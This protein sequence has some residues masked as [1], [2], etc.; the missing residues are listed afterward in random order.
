MLAPGGELEA[1]SPLA[2]AALESLRAY[3]EFI[4]ELEEES[5]RSIDFRRSGAIGLAFSDDELEALHSRSLRQADLGILSEPCVH[6]GRPGRFYP[7]DAVVDPR[8]VTGAL[9][10]ACRRRGVQIL[11]SEPV[12]NI[13]PDGK[14]VRTTKAVHEAEG[15]LI[16]AGAWSSALLPGLPRTMPVRGHLISWSLA[17]G[18]L[19]PILRH[20]HTYLLQR[21]SGE[22]IAGASTESVGFDRTLDESALADIQRRAAFL[23]PEL[24]LQPPQDRWNGF[25]PG[26]EAEGP[27]IGRVPGTSIWTAFGHYRNG[28]LLAPETARRIAALIG[29]G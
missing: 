27:A 12:L 21:R 17:P 3:P 26:I 20:G 14:S 24:G 18:R 25:R 4:R 2:N 22:L 6:L 9:Q 1:S 23:M 16:A 28:I 10:V 7:D 11:E 13:A 15:V 5:G 8:D 19:C 29:E